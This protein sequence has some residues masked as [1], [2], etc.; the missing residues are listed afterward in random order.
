MVYVEV[1]RDIRLHV[2]DLGS[3]TPVVLVAGFG[4]DHQV[5]DRQVRVLAERY[6]VICV[7]QRGH[8]LSDKPL[9]G[10]GVD[11]L[12]LDLRAAL[13]ALEVRGC[14]MVGWSFGGQVAFQVA[15]EDPGLVERLVL[16]G[17]NGVR[18]SRSAEFPFGLVPEKLAPPL[19]EAEKRDRLSARRATIAGGF[20]ENPGEDVL[21]WLLDRSLQMPSWAAVSCYESMLFTDLTA[22]IPRVTMPV[23]QLIGSDDPVHSAKG[24][25]W[26]NDRLSDS[27]L[28]ELPGCGHYPMLEAAAEFDAALL[29]FLDGR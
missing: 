10:Y 23:L 4:L 12:G 27:R 13:A 19:V 26:L 6:R 24:A 22:E 7:D 5:W 14:A 9:G 11:R 8:G 29:A 17:S 18:A 20:A 21:R 15:A 2:Q 16:V 3:G 25:R 28:V 1:D